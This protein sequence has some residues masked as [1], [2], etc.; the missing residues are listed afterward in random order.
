MGI[1]RGDRRADAIAGIRT[2]R[3]L[4][5]SSL[6]QAAAGLGA[7]DMLEVRLGLATPEAVDARSQYV[8]L[9]V[10]EGSS[11]GHD[12]SDCETLGCVSEDPSNA[13]VSALAGML[14]GDED[15]PEGEDEGGDG[16]R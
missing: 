16:P 3:Q 4:L 2:V 14:E 6:V 7:L 9:H 15:P 12:L 10:P 13:S 5:E 8:T 11:E 1:V